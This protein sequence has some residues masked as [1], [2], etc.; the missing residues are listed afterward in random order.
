MISY[1]VAPNIDP[2]N[3]LNTDEELITNYSNIKNLQ[4]GKTSKGVCFNYALNNYD[5]DFEDYA[6]DTLYYGYIPIKL[7]EAKKG[8]IITYHNVNW[9]IGKNKKLC[10]GFN[11]VHFA[12]IE[13]VGKTIQNTIIRSKWGELGIYETKINDV[14]NEYGNRILIWR[15]RES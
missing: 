1:K 2:D 8:D 11:C 5:Y 13:K 15:K 10:G 12:V 7:S 6:F 3:V 4:M 9:N 14:P